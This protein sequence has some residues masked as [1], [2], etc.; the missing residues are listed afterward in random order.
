MRMN[1]F[2]FDCQ[3]IEKTPHSYGVDDNINAA[4]RIAQFR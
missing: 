1:I 4:H 2:Y 3:I